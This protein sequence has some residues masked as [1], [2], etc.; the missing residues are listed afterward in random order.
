MRGQYGIGSF[1][2]KQRMFYEASTRTELIFPRAVHNAG[3][4]AY[5]LMYCYRSGEQAG[6]R[7]SASLRQTAVSAAPS[8]VH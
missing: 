3:S 4:H 7:G 1:G 2:V 8:T 6:L 5:G